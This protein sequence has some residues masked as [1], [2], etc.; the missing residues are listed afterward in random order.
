MT[1]IR[2]S[3]RL[4]L[5]LLL[6]VTTAGCPTLLPLG[7]GSK[8]SS[9]AMDV[10]LPAL[11]KP[12]SLPTAGAAPSA[13]SSVKPAV[14]PVATPSVAT[15]SAPA[16]SSVAATLASLGTNSWAP[17]TPMIC[18]RQGL[19]TAEA[20]NR[21][22]AIGGDGTFTDETFD[23]ATGSWQR[24][25]SS[26]GGMRTNLYFMGGVTVATQ[27]IVLGGISGNEGAPNAI[28]LVLPLDTSSP[29]RVPFAMLSL[30]DYVSLY[31]MGVAALNGYVYVAGGRD[32]FGVQ[33]G[34]YVFTDL[35]PPDRDNPFGSFRL[36]TRSVEMKYP[37]AG[38]GLAAVS[39]KLYAI[40]G[41]T[42]ASA[43]E[44]MSAHNTVQ[45][46]TPGALSWTA[47]DDNGGPLAMPTKRYNFGT[48][49][50]NNRIYVIG[51]IDDQG[52]CLRTVEIYN[53]A[54]NQWSTGAPMPSARSA[55]SLIV[56]Q[57]Q[58]FALGGVEAN[59]RASRLV[60]VY[61]P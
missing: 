9:T 50:V 7:M 56:H 14:T 45:V 18:P 44:V 13:T 39:G 51:G 21:L 53:P 34:T 28:G 24:F 59:G 1:P 32:Y 4:A 8:A 49:V 27:T 57:G 37:R 35:T 36:A 31:G 2:Q 58:I 3:F 60:E 25:P 33:S 47:S 6:M 5:P 48:A 19:V 41:Y 38:L 46:Y 10:E 22:Y 23:F 29:P 15:P 40:G 12:S 16:L 42:M 11:V 30:P 61:A 54:T 52:R 17:F 55:L 43:V 26:I 20:G